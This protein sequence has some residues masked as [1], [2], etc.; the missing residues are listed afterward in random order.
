MTDVFVHGMC[1]GCSI[2]AALVALAYLVI[3]LLASGGRR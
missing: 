1:A 2:M 3:T